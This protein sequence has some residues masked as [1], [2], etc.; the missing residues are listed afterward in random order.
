M[1][2][3]QPAQATRWDILEPRVLL[4]R[5][6]LDYSFG[7]AGLAQINA[8]VFVAPLSDG[9]AVAVSPSEAVRISADGTIDGAFFDQGFLQ[10]GLARLDWIASSAVVSGSRLYIAGVPRSRQANETFDSDTVFVRAL[11]LA[12]GSLV[13]SFGDHGFM[14]VVI[15]SLTPGD[16]VYHA[17]LPSIAATADGGFVF[18]VAQRSRSAA[19]DEHSAV[20]LYKSDARGRLS[21]TFGG[22]GEVVVPSQHDEDLA[23][24]TA[25]GLALDAYAT[26]SNRKRSSSSG[27]RV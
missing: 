25:N 14:E 19:G 21:H 2:T 3:T 17:D 15:T 13:D 1:P 6:G 24:A 26:A 22:N 16:T 12:D 5:M 8:G 10:A 7:T 20:T 27:V 23:F 9:E 4:A 18:T 11:N